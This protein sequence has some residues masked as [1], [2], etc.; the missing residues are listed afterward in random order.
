[1][2]EVLV[3]LRMTTKE[4]VLILE[5]LDSQC[6]TFKKKIKDQLRTQ[7]ATKLL[8]QAKLQNMLVCCHL[9]LFFRVHPPSEKFFFLSFSDG[10]D[11]TNPYL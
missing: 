4:V 11:S 1:M 9:S 7:K 5:N 8:A 2:L 10:K 6:M 3:L